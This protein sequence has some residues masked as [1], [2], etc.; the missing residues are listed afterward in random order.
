MVSMFAAKHYPDIIPGT[1]LDKYLARGWYRMGQTVFT[2]HFLCFGEQFYSALWI[3]L[4]LNDHHFSKSL[5]K[6]LRRNTD[7]YRVV[8]RPAF[9]NAE[10]E[11][12]YQS[13][14]RDFPG[15]LAPT[16]H[17][18]L[19][20]GETGNIFNTFEAA[21]YDG[22]RLIAVSFFDLGHHAA[23]SIQ[24][25]YDP[26]YKKDS[27]GLF[28][29][30]LEIRYCMEQGYEYY[31]PGYVVPGNSRFDYKLRIGKTCEYLNIQNQEWLPW[32]SLTKEDIPLVQM[33]QRLKDLKE[34]LRP[35]GFRSAVKFY[36]LFEANLFGFWRVPF[37]D[38]PLFLLIEVPGQPRGH[39]TLCVWDPRSSAYKLLQGS[40]FDDIQFY[41]N[42]AYTNSFQSPRYF[43]DLLTTERLLHLSE[44]PESIVQT[45]H[46]L[47]EN[48]S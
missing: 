2:T 46:N 23:A 44:E 18:S 48:S 22:A 43:V 7:K 29:M 40:N 45:I 33:E 1:E 11:T 37:F 15:I 4:P 6:L 10:K 17:D 26:E 8:F 5:R 34:V 39:Y 19:L 9:I 28:T 16:L 30:L 14:K 21:V 42:E 32:S 41:F 36:P 20:D 24:G 31:Y 25:I 3:R 13:Y 47:R 27:L 12:L 38:Y 35:E